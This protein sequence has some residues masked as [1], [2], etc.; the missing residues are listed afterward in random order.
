[1]PDYYRF[2]EEYGTPLYITNLEEV[3]SRYRKINESL[4]DF[5]VKYASKANFDPQ[6]INRL[7]THNPD[8]VAGSTFEAMY[9]LEEAGI[10]ADRLQVTAVSPKD[11]S[12]EHLVELSNMSSEFTATVNEYDT[13][14]KLVENEFKGRILV[15]L[16]PDKDLQSASKYSNGS[17]LKFGMTESEIRMTLDD[18][19]DS[20]YMELAGFHSHLGGSFLTEEVDL[21]CEHV[22]RTVEKS[23]NHVDLDSIDVINFGGG[24][25]IPYSRTEKE[26]DL[27]VFKKKLHDV[28][29][30]LGIEYVIEPGRYVVGPSTVLLTK[31]QATRNQDEGRFVGVDAGMSEFARTT[32]FDV[33][34]EI[35]NNSDGRKITSQTVAGPTCSGADIF[36]H[37]RRFENAEVGDILN[38][39]DVGAYGSVMSSNFHAYPMP[40]IIDENGNL[41]P[42][43]DGI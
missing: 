17:L 28:V 16:K 20:K 24:M 41:S 31:V 2:V 39:K 8:F 1:M 7:D 13:V 6:V 35:E 5:T 12:I 26:L 19:Q 14:Q 42:I 38:I 18:V 29:P 30:D 23:R 36:C 15:R 33:Y 27:T 11:A 3:E 25:G 34:H 21:F 10:A 40:T 43:S 9:I 4:S 32:M 37:N 22:E